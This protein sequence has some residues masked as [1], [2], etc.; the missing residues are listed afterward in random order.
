M[1]FTNSY[2]TYDGKLTLCCRDY[3]G[4][5]TAGDI[6][7][8]SLDELWDGEQ[9]EKIRKQHTSPDTLEIDACLNCFSPYEF[10]SNITN[11]F[12][13]Y[14]YLKLP[15]L[16]QKKFGQVIYS[17]LEG[18]NECMETKDIDALKQFVMKAFDHVREKNV[19]FSNKNLELQSIP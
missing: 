18:M 9:A 16:P 1:P 2:F 13:H 11:Y 10:I 8:S 15:E 12:V 17:F 19:S 7:T 5:I 14:L 6:M 3:N 4:E